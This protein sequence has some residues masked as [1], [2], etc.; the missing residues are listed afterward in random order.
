MSLSRKNVDEL[1][2]TIL[3]CAIEVH[4]HLGP[5]LLESV[6]ERCMLRE[7]SIRN[8]QTSNQGVIPLEYKGL[9][10]DAQLR[11]DI[12]VEDLIVVELKAMD[13]ILPIHEAVLLTYMKMLRKPKG[14]IINFNCINI[15]K[16]GQ[17]TFVNEYYANLPGE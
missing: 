8:L 10:L 7:L 2:Y 13:G 17:K 14:V 3:G 16:Y 9:T 5:G 6:Y 12:L 11:Y 15:F 4:K 1:T